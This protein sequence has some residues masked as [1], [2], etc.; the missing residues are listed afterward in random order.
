MISEMLLRWPRPCSGRRHAL[1]QPLSRDDLLRDGDDSIGFVI[2]RSR[3]LTARHLGRELQLAPGDAT[4]MLMSATG[5]VGWRESSTLFDMLIPPTE[6]EA[7][8]ARSEDVLM[9]RLWGKSEAMQLLRCYI[10]SLE[11]SGLAAFGND[12]TIVRRHIG[13]SRRA[14]R[15]CPLPHR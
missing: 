13:R 10:R 2:A 9:Q 6:W 7:R 8:G 11:R 15:N 12:H 1:F 5:G 4:M 14:R 3:E